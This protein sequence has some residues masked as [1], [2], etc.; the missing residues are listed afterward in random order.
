[1]IVASPAPNADG[2]GGAYWLDAYAA[3]AAPGD[4]V[5]DTSNRAMWAAMADELAATSGGDL[6]QARARIQRQVEDIGTGFRLSGDAEVRKWPLSPLPLMIDAREWAGIADAV[7]Q[8]AQL[9]ELLLDDIYGAQRLIG[10]GLL[11]AALLNGSPHFL[12]PMVGLPPPGGHHLHFYAADIAR[13]PSGK[14]RVIA[15]HTRTPTGAGYALENRLAVA[16]DMPGLQAR[17][18]IERLAP[19]FADVR[20]GIAASCQRTDPRIAI[21]TPGRFNPSYGEQAHLARYLGMLLVEGEDLAVHD[22]KLYLRTI[23]GAKRVDALWRRIDPRLL[24]PLAFDSHSRIGVPGLVDAMAAGNVVIAN[25]PGAGVLESTAFAAFLPRL[26]VRL[27]GEDLRLPNIATWWCGQ[28]AAR[29]EVIAAFHGMLIAPAFTAVPPGLPKDG[30]IGGALEGAARDALLNAIRRRGVDYVGQELV[31]L[32]T[33]PTVGDNGLEPRP[34]SLRVFAT[35]DGQ[36]DWRV[37]AGGFARIGEHLDVHA[38][39][40]GEGAMSADV[41]IVSDEPVAPVTLMQA[42]DDVAIRRNPGTLPARVADNLFWL[43]RYLE[44][45][46]SVLALVR[47]GLGGSVDVDGGAA[48]AGDTVARL[49]TL[50]VAN[51]AAARRAQGRDA[52][53]ISLAR[54]ALDDAQEMSSVRSILKHAHAIGDGSRERIASDVWRLL[55]AP[56]PARDAMMTRASQ[57]HERLAAL[58]GL[59]AETMGR[60]AGWR[61]LD[62]GRRIERAITVCRLLRALGTDAASADDLSA[63]LE[64]TNSAISYRQRY[65]TGLSP[66]AVRDL[67]ALDSGNPRSLAFQVD[68]IAAHLA[69]LPRLS[70]DGVAE[71]QQQLA[72]ALLA[73]LATRTGWTMGDHDVQGIENRLLALSDAIAHRFF[74]RG[75]EPMRASALK[76]G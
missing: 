57:L 16:R 24:D 25:A 52:D 45:A 2:Q 22:D 44:R 7:I 63:L 66:V 68:A 76:V 5:R 33:L 47:A 8:R 64:L 17:L 1:L 34:F 36:G 75:A 20:A 38:A 35:R 60:T 6:N 43:G 39:L 50:L 55:D 3:S 13:G 30:V 26:S 67:I 56:F 32:S 15:D 74:L 46:E 10:N 62:L 51:G 65:P 11:P 59:S 40:F 23:E 69:A 12:R 42:V 4:V 31:K 70:D 54:A 53:I 21:L 49:G 37:M 28:D 72:T 27:T 14:W 29:D 61:F 58:A 19:F 9:M 18:N 48:L 41:C 71:V 73:D